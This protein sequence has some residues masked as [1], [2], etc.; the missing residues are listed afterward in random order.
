MKIIYFIAILMKMKILTFIPI[1]YM[2][3]ATV[4]FNLSSST[5]NEILLRNFFFTVFVGI[6]NAYYNFTVMY[7]TYEI[8]FSSKT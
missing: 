4:D 1:S 7:S 6:P 5:S 3:S 8:S 2:E